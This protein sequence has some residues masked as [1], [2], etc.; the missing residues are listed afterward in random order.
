VAIRDDK[1]DNIASFQPASH[2]TSMCWLRSIPFTGERLGRALVLRRNT[3]IGCLHTGYGEL[4]TIAIYNLPGTRC[5]G[6]HPIQLR[7]EMRR[8]WGRPMSKHKT[9][10]SQ[11]T[12]P[13]PPF[14][15]LMIATSL[16]V[17]RTIDETFGI[18]YATNLDVRSSRPS[19]SKGT[20]SDESCFGTITHV[21]FIHNSTPLP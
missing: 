4:P 14:A 8:A 9:Q 7:S 11:M 1:L 6:E 3:L 17:S 19:L 12:F 16:R 5:S 20:L 15:S 21:S 13:H 2:C 18:T 10:P